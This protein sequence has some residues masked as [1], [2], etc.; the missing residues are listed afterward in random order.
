MKIN[1]RIFQRFWENYCGSGQAGHL[2]S[3]R[4]CLLQRFYKYEHL[5]ISHSSSALI[6]WVWLPRSGFTFEELF[7]RFP[8]RSKNI[9]VV[10]FIAF[11]IFCVVA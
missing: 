11:I 9:C 2:S 5:V 7:K 3:T 1:R 10:C 4:V 8:L 6:S